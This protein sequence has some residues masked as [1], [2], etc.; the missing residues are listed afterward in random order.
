MSQKGSHS[1]GLKPR[2]TPVLWSGIN[3]DEPGQNRGGTV[4][5]LV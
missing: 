2:F 4:E 1:A 5:N 3:R